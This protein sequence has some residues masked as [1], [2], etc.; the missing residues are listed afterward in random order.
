MGAAFGWG[1]LA[2]SSLVI[3]ALLAF[4]L[5]INLRAIGLVIGGIAV[6]TQLNPYIVAL[7]L[8][9]SM[10]LIALSVWLVRLTRLSPRLTVSP[11][12]AAAPRI[13][14]VLMWLTVWL[15][16]VVTGSGPH[17]GDANV[18]RNGQR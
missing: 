14:F 6:L 5:P 8:L 11:G 10:V 1:L 18:P 12:V 2:A 3:G 13:A 9:L 17:A 4:F 15:G 16:T 7:H